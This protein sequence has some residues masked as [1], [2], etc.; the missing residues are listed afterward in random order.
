MINIVNDLI[1][2]YKSPVAHT[3][4]YRDLVDNPMKMA[5]VR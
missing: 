4:G 2:C 1:L 5:D 3:K